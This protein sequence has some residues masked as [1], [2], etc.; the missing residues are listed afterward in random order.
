MLIMRMLESTARQKCHLRLNEVSKLWQCHMRFDGNNFV[1][2]A[3]VLIAD[4]VSGK[5]V[6]IDTGLLSSEERINLLVILAEARSPELRDDI[7]G[8]CAERDID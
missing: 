6:T 2:H 1:E 7:G 5:T 4:P 8:G 3:A